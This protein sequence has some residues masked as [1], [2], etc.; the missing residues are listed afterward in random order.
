MVFLMQE[1]RRT[2]AE[3]AGHFEVSRRTVLRDVQALCEM[4]MPV[5]AEWGPNGG[6][7][8]PAGTLGS[9]ALTGRE[10]FAL[11]VA[12]KSVGPVLPMDGSAA[13]ET[14]AAKIRALI[15]AT[16]RR[17]ADELLE[18]VYVGAGEKPEAPYVERI[19]EVID[20]DG[21]MEVAYTSTR[22]RSTQTLQPE[23]L[24][25]EEGFWYLRAYSLER[26]A[27]R[28]YRVDRIGAIR[29]CAPPEHGIGPDVE[30]RYGDPRLPEVVIALTE[31]GAMEA[32]RSLP[33]LRVVREDG[34]PRI[35]FHCPPSEYPWYARAVLGMGGEARA[36]APAELVAA[37]ADLA[38]TIGAV[39]EKR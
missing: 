11:L 14:L 36:L 5:T 3:L 25:L 20:Q 32:D 6:Y 21:W 33:G 34:E 27:T 4:G 31:G 22:G 2:G 12:L 13:R 1:R 35:R 28:T 37:V 39:H 29:R 17:G 8:L 24:T 26:G 18:H 19:L 10:A 15:P 7:S 30:P 9:V 23:Q 38:R 16:V